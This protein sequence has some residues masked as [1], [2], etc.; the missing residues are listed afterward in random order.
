MSLS[1]NLS[2]YDNSSS[3]L[4]FIYS[5]YSV[6]GTNLLY[7]ESVLHIDDYPISWLGTGTGHIKRQK[8]REREKEKLGNMIDDDELYEFLINNVIVKYYQEI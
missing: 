8:K 7:N 2:L 5:R 1:L 3:I 4:I 6:I